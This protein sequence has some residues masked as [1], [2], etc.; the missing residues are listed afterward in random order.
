M[1]DEVALRLAE[2]REQARDKAAEELVG[3]GSAPIGSRG[4]RADESQE[5]AYS[6]DDSDSG[7]PQ[8]DDDAAS[9]AAPVVGEGADVGIAHSGSDDD[10]HFF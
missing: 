2:E 8:S 7:T 9:L 1:V 3:F 6:A 4:K 5:P 10:E